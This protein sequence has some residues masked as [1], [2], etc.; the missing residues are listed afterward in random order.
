MTMMKR[1]T[2][3]DGWKT[4]I[5]CVETHYFWK[6][7]LKLIKQDANDDEEDDDGDSY[8]EEEESE[9]GEEES[10][11]EEGEEESEEEED[12]HDESV[13]E[14]DA[15]EEYELVSESSSMTGSPKDH[16]PTDKVDGC[17]FNL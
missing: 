3:I 12:E 10:E 1:R 6:S 7:S 14:S 8:D 13:E 11:D 9:E 17:F 2:K 16:L 5:L 4:L 15:D